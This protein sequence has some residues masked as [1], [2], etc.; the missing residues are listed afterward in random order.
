MLFRNCLRRLFAAVFIL[1][2]ILV[3]PAS[4]VY[5]SAGTGSS[6]GVSASP[7][8]MPDNEETR[9]LL[10]QT[11]SSAEIEREIARITVEQQTLEHEVAMLEK[12]AADKQTS[13]ADKQ[14]QAGAVVRAYYM[15]ERDGLLTAFLSAKSIS[16]LLA[17]VDY[18]EIIMGQDR[19]TLTEYE[20]QYKDLKSTLTAAQ[21]SSK[22][23]TELKTALEEQQT[24]VLALNKEIEGGIQASTD[25]AS[26]E[27][28]LEEFSKYWESIGLHEVRTYF[29]A[30]ASA[31]KHLPEFVQNRDGVLVRKGMTY[32]LA[33]SQEDL[34]TFLVS[35]N[36]LFQDFRFEFKDHSITATG[37][38]GGLSLSL[39][40]RYT[41][42]KEPVNGLMFH[43]D[44][45]VFNG[46][47]LPDT[48][49]QALEEE[50]DLGFYPSKIVSFLQATEVSS[51]DGILHVKLS[52]SF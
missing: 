9:K 3:P 22:E 52:L 2:C 38:S 44:H 31:M 41:I 42:Q 1:T 48:T 8:S 32:N 24:R 43:V 34:N 13:I 11:L 7:P 30:L 14:E 16:R 5:L 50:F 19:R 21:R 47:E 26:M 12:Q 28:L 49:R 25:P 40:G 46:L 35:Q 17:L 20:D 6:S 27:R 23:L 51:S 39:T 37:Q 45:V 15:G 29:K 4:T 10:E 18:Y 36:K 33:L